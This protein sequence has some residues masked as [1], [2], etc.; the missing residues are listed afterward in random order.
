MPCVN[1]IDGICQNK[2]SSQQVKTCTRCK[3]TKIIDDFSIGKAECKRCSAARVLEWKRANRAEVNRQNRER[4]A[5]VRKAAIEKLG[6]KCATCN[7]ADERVLQIDHIDGGGNEERSLKHRV[8]IWNE[9]IKGATGY[10]LLC[11]NCH[12][13]KSFENGEFGNVK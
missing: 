13:I 7:I 12:C 10:Q 5:A 6:G 11:A 2:C 4:T 8:T 1:C 9:I 3:T